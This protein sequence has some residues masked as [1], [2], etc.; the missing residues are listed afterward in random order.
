MSALKFARVLVW[1]VYAFLVLAVIILTLAFFLLL[2]NASTS[3]PF[4]QWVYRSANRLLEPFRGIFPS[5]EGGNGSVLDF[6]VLF[7][8][9]MYGIFAMLVH[10][11]V[12]WL[13]GRISLLRAKRS[14][15]D[16]RNS[17]VATAAPQAY[18]QPTD[19]PPA[20]P[21]PGSAYSS[22]VPTSPPPAEQYPQPPPA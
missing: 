9:I 22:P 1:L 14:E 7:A 13:D 11:L 20:Q 6:A 12:Y 19:P 18:P 3:A 2:F 10:A 15:A 17:G 21:Y 5:A 16:S 4:T 8:I